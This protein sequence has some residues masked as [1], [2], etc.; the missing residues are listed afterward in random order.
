MVNDET[1][2]NLRCGFQREPNNKKQ[3]P[4]VDMRVY[5]KHVLKEGNATLL[6]MRR[7]RGLPS[8]YKLLISPA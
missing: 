4:A 5:V 2:Y 8:G 7:G 1:L 6:Q 3:N